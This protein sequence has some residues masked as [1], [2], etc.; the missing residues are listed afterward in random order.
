MRKKP[1]ATVVFPPNSPH[2]FPQVSISQYPAHIAGTLPISFP[3][4]LSPS[5]PPTL[6]G[7]SPYLSP[8]LYLPVPRPRAGEDILAGLHHVREPQTCSRGDRENGRLHQGG[9]ASQL[10]ARR[11]PLLLALP[12]RSR[13][14]NGRQVR[15]PPRDPRGAH[16]PEG[17]G[18]VR[19]PRPRRATGH[20]RK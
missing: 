8:G 1:K 13:V 4:Y 9:H 2:I 15:L 16:A 7:L 3:R 17:Q 6:Q 5:T 18:Q 10:S 11:H 19:R 14:P 20:E 12:R